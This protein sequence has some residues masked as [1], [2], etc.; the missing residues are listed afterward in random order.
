MTSFSSVGLQGV[1][2]IILLSVLT[3]PQAEPAVVKSSQVYRVSASELVEIGN[4]K[5]FTCSQ[6]VL[7]N[8][9]T[10]SK[11]IAHV[12]I[13]PFHP[14]NLNFNVIFVSE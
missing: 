14:E 2:P 13:N 6:K 7:V 11:I 1:T 8:G 5:D 9:P 12:K 10:G 3:G 4:V